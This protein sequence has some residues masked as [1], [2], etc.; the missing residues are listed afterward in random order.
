M[1]PVHRGWLLLLLLLL[2][3]DM[4]LMLDILVRGN[5]LIWNIRRGI[6]SVVTVVTVATLLL[7]LW[8]FWSTMI[9]PIIVV[10]G[11]EYLVLL[12]LVLLLVRLCRRR[13]RITTVLYCGGTRR[14][15]NSRSG[16]RLG[17]RRSRRIGVRCVRQDGWQWASHGGRCCWRLLLDRHCGRSGGCESC[18]RRSSRRGVIV[19]V[20]WLKPKFSFTA[21]NIILLEGL[22]QRDGCLVV[23]K[24][25]LIQCCVV[26]FV[27]CQ[28]RRTKER[29]CKGMSSVPFTHT[30][31]HTHIKLEHIYCEQSNLMTLEGYVQFP[32]L[33]PK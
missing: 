12:L 14:R 30:Q 29:Q 9:C 25:A 22:L 15:T 17:H 21:M 26:G 13:R 28:T 18:R 11:V 27:G 10:V 5:S 32:N 31:T 16:L 24:V 33:S 4:L 7:L 6:V 1:I 8:V 20:W 3:L 2:L 23:T 19:I